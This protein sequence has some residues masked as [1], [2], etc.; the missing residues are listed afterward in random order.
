MIMRF[1]VHFLGTGGAAP[2]P[3][4]FTT[5]QAVNIQ[6]NWFLVDCG[7]G[8]QM[9]I[10]K[11]GVKWGRIGHIFISHMHGDHIYGL[12]GL[13]TS[14]SLNSRTQPL[15][16]FG[17]SMLE[18]FILAQLQYTGPL[19]FALH[20]HHTD[21]SATHL[22]YENSQLEVLSF[23]LLHRVPTTG[24]LFRE[25]KRLRNIIPDKIEE[26]GINYTQ[27]PA[28]K[29]GKD[30]ILNDGQF[31]PNEELTVA[32]P[33]PRAYAFC[34]DTAYHER[35]AEIVKGVDLLYHESTFTEAHRQQAEITMHS[36]AKQAAEI[37]R[38][39]GAGQLALGHFSP[40]YKNLE[41]LLGEAQR[42][43]PNTIVAYDGLAIAIPQAQRLEP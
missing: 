19:S 39:S 42:V 4:R 27:I 28:I 9:R 15:H 37:A 21:A 12:I 1:E 17:P 29:E 43:F 41:P 34:S 18:G 7:E 31:I 10:S 3:E 25:K 26:Y 32:P 6:E 20:F 14:M 13:L 16:V 35:L 2:S 30:L 36:T 23:P 8:T 24:F 38:L 5:A 33:E 22:L 40:R 11:Y